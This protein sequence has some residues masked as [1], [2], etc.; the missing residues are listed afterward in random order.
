MTVR[1]PSRVEGW[2]T[3]EGVG[4]GNSYGGNAEGFE[5]GIAPKRSGGAAHIRLAR[6]A[7]CLS[8]SRCAG[9]LLLSLAVQRVY[10]RGGAERYPPS[11]SPSVTGPEARP[12]GVVLEGADASGQ[13]Y[14]NLLCPPSPTG[15]G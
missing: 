13:S 15:F 12:L 10:H 1:T 4:T 6:P 8:G 3:P 11:P 7:N 2:E 14:H 9:T 5:K